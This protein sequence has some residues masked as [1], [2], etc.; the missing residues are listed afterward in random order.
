MYEQF[1]C[2]DYGD[3]YPGGNFSAGIAGEAFSKKQT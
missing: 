3:E 2:V 1:N